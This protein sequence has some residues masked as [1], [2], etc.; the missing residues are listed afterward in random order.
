MCNSSVDQEILNYEMCDMFKN[1]KE[2]KDCIS[3]DEVEKK[4][5]IMKFAMQKC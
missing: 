1:V 2:N 3:E 4:Y 5:I